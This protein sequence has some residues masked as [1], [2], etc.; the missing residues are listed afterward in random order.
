VVGSLQPA[1]CSLVAK[2][3]CE[4]ARHAFEVSLPHSAAVSHGRN[5][6]QTDIKSALC[7]VLYIDRSSGGFLAMCKMGLVR[8]L[9]ELTVRYCLWDKIMGVA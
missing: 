2:V 4:H 7:T 1:L 8:L 6:S 3:K 9:A 5:M